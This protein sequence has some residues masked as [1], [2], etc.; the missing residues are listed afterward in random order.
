MKYLLVLGVVMFG[1]WL[2]RSNRRAD[3]AEQAKA[4]PQRDPQ[5][6]VAL[7]PQPMLQCAVCGVHLPQAD[8]EQGKSGAYCSTAH[9]KQV[10]G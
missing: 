9:R 1:F 5:A 4:K 7:S 10:E 8:A 3:K 2:W 6:P